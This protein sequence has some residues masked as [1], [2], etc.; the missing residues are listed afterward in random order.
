[1]RHSLHPSTCACIPSN[2]PHLGCVT[3][4]RQLT[5]MEPLCAG[6]TRCTH[7]LGRR[8][9]QWTCVVLVVSMCMPAGTTLVG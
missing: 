5:G 6:G 3:N 7:V 9:R 8:C 4:A 1:M 2:S